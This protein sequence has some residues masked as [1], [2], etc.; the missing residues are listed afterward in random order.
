MNNRFPVRFLEKGPDPDQDAT[1]MILQ[2]RSRYKK[3]QKKKTPETPVDTTQQLTDKNMKT[4]PTLGTIQARTPTL[5]DELTAA[6]NSARLLQDDIQNVDIL[7]QALETELYQ[8]EQKIQDLLHLVEFETLDRQ[9][10]Y[11]LCK[12]LHR[13]R[14]ERRKLK[15]M[16]I[17]CDHLS[18][19]QAKNSLSALADAANL[20]DHLANRRY[21][22]RGMTI[23][24]I[25]EILNGRPYHRKT[26]VETQ[27]K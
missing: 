9:Q 26:P 22:L 21:A 10:S 15:D 20:P 3:L 13:L 23:E 7:K 12:I 2:W 18:S 4:T 11:R 27:D 5:P 17:Y 24:E 14:I 1:S 16:M 19:T 8:Y 25:N 6:A